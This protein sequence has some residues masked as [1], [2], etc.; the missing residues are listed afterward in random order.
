[1]SIIE[2][3]LILPLI[4]AGIIYFSAKCI[5]RILKRNI[6]RYVILLLLT[7]LIASYV[8]LYLSEDDGCG[9]GAIF[10]FLIVFAVE[11]FLIIL[12]LIEKAYKKFRFL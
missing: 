2:I 7:I 12:L 3:L 4:I 8:F 10:I 1:M 11:L 6:V 9:G 5:E